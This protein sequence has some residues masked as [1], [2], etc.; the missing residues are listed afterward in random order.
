[1]PTGVAKPLSPADEWEERLLARQRSVTR[2]IACAAGLWLAIQVIAVTELAVAL[3]VL[4]RLDLDVLVTVGMIWAVSVPFAGGAAVFALVNWPLLTRC[5]RLGGGRS[6]ID[7]CDRGDG[8]VRTRGI[9]WDGGRPRCSFNYSNVEDR[10][11][12]L[13]GMQEMISCI[14]PRW[15]VFYWWSFS[16][17]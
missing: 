15:L 7:D 12:L 16:Q 5:T 17:F 13:I 14:G 8:V 10:Y 11:A 9:R 4:W 3:V 1:M 2:E 6:E